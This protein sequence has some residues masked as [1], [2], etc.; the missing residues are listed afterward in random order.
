MADGFDKK[1]LSEQD[2]RTKYITPAIMAA[3]WDIETQLREEYGLTAGR[4]VAKV[5]ELMALCDDLEAK[6][7]QAETGR[8]KLMEAVVRKLSA[9]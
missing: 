1:S 6:L 3:G 2:I 8:E 4:I 9:A 5:D 7:T